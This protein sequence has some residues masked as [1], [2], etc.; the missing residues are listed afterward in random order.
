M[1]ELEKLR[2]C[3]DNTDIIGPDYYDHFPASRTQAEWDRNVRATGVEGGPV[4]LQRWLEFCQK[5]GRPLGIGEWGIGAETA[6][7]VEQPGGDN[8]VF[9]RNMIGFVSRNRNWMAYEAYFNSE[10][11]R[12][13]GSGQPTSP[14]ASAAYREAF[15]AIPE[16][17]P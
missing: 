9:I 5:K 17:I 8:P 12:L 10:R 6:E 16:F 4:G 15:A 3:P 13:H 14:A 2:Y 1:A 11:H 7:E